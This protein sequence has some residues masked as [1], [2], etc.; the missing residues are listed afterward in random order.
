MVRGASQCNE[1]AP[2]SVGQHE[3]NVAASPRE[4]LGQALNALLRT[5]L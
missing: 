2:M 1:A 3:W 5:R 4:T